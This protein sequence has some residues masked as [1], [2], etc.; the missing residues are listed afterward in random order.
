MLRELSLPGIF[1]PLP[2]ILQLGPLFSGEHRLEPSWW[3][4]N[5]VHSLP[6]GVLLFS[7]NSYLCHAMQ[8]IIPKPC[9]LKQQV[10]I[11]LTSRWVGNLDWAWL[12]SSGLAAPPQAMQCEVQ[13]IWH[14]L[15]CS[16]GAG[17]PL[18]YPLWALSLW[19]GP[20][21]HRQ[22]ARAS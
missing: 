13:L 22:G 14:G 9:N 17:T 8:E 4:S 11:W 3:G 21:C 18:C 19:P 2:F 15:G 12:G 10:F 1:I 7:V 16:T 6:K 5:C 20:G